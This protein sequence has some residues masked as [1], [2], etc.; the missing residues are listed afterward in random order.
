MYV[1]VIS[2]PIKL[3]EF[4]AMHLH[5]CHAVHTC[6]H[7]H[8]HVYVYIYIYTFPWIKV[9]VYSLLRVRIVLLTCALCSCCASVIENR[10]WLSTSWLVVISLLLLSCFRL[11]VASSCVASSFASLLLSTVVSLTCY[12]YIYRLPF[13]YKDVA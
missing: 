5:M 12:I 11:P 7:V 6:M 3:F 8:S 4:L 1:V 13:P 2:Y 9:F 10:A